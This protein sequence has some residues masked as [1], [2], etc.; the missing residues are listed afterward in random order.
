MR[1]AKTFNAFHTRVGDTPSGALYGK[2]P[3]GGYTRKG[4]LS[5][6]R[7]TEG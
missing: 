3:G 2:T 5:G 7:F 1:D 4:D 6:F